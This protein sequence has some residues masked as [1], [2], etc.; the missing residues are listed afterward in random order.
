VI[1]IAA[2]PPATTPTTNAP[3]TVRSVHVTYGAGVTRDQLA[4]TADKII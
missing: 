1:R 2:N 3:A 4:C